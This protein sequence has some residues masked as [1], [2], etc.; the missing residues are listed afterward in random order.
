MTITMTTKNQ[1]TLPKKIVDTLHLRKGSLF[2]VRVTQNRIE[3][4]PL[5][6][7]EKSFNDEDFKRLDKLVKEEKKKGT[8]KITPEFIKN[9]TNL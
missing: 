2:N 4:V 7:T 8:K 5:E 1:I 9:I 3:L 6:V